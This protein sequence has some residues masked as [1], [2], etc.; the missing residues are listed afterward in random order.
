MARQL[1]VNLPVTDLDR[2][3]RFFTA[4]GFTFDADFTDEATACMVVNEQASV[5]LH[6]PERYTS[7]TD[8]PIADATASSEA[9]FCISADSREDVDELIG[10]ALANGGTSA[11]ASEAQGPMYGGTFYDPDGHHW[12]VMYMDM[13][14]MAAMTQN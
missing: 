14:A 12:E 13:A 11:K 6:T 7:F 3:V 1:F 10:A 9:I 8:Q 4:L 2:S 5:L